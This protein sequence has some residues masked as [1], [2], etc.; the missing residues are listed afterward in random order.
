LLVSHLSENFI[1]VLLYQE[2]S[3][4]E[5]PEEHV[6]TAWVQRVL[7]QELKKL[8]RLQFVFLNDSSLL[9]INQDHLQHDTLTDII[10]FPYE[11]NPIDAEI[12]ISIDRVRENATT[13]GV[14]IQQEILRVM[15]HGLL[16][17]CGWNDKTQSESL[18]M[19]KRENAC[20]DLFGTPYSASSPS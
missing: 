12:F 19:R 18:L 6:V 1:G 20:L 5:L 3:V 15:A 17:L 8:H 2:E 10:T 14:P 7:T 11:T 13:Y 9:K 4:P 16:H